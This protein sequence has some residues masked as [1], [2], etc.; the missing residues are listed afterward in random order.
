VFD[1]ELKW[2]RPARAGNN[3]TKHVLRVRVVPQQGGRSLPL[4]LAVALDTSGSMDGAKLD[5]ARAACLTVAELLRPQ[6]R[7]SL[8]AFS[9]NVQRLLTDQAGGPGAQAE[10]RRA[11]GSLTAVGV[12]RTDM[13]LEWLLKALPRE[14]GVARVGILIS[15]GHATDAAGKKLTDTALL[16]AS[17][18]GIGQAGI[19]LCAVGLGSAT[20]FDTPFLTDLANRGR[21]AFLFAEGAGTLG[22]ELQQQLGVVQSVGVSD[23]RLTVSV[24]KAGVR[25]AE[26]CVARPEFRP[27]EWSEGQGAQ[28]AGVG[29]LA[30]VEPTDLLLRVT[31]PPGGFAAPTGPQEVLHITVE[32]G[33]A[34]AVAT[35]SLEWAASL[36]RGQMVNDDV[37]RERNEWD[38]R[39]YGDLVQRATDPHHTAEL[40]QAQ[41]T[42]AA[43]AGR[44][45]IAAAATGQLEDLRKTGNLDLDRSTRTLAAGRKQGGNS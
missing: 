3:D 1:L 33:G 37:E 39:L 38:M 45:E 27:L 32:G 15:D 2:D 19:T 12:T 10:V 22:H 35:A 36:T 30:A 31:A 44:P 41:A 6:D 13:A 16:V 42:A 43:A 4:R 25:V 9:T 28:S 21:G 5:G 40:L 20:Q 8:A 24:R 26:A 23:A 14:D 18:G 7:L 29:D 11:I 17:A 34:S